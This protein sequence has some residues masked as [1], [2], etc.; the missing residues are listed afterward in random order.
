MTSDSEIARNA[1]FEILD[2]QLALGN[3]PET[4]EAFARLLADGHSEQEV[5]RLIACVVAS[6]IFA[7]VQE[8]LE[9]DSNKYAQALSALPKLPWEGPQ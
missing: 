3:P 2:N 7:V 4:R 5:R 8:G 1:I 9:F 6:E